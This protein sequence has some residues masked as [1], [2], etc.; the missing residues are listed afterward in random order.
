MAYTN[1][2]IN[3]GAGNFGSYQAAAAFAIYLRGKFVTPASA[4]GKA[5]IDLAGVTET[6]DVVAMTPIAS[7]AW[8]TV[9]FANSGGE[10]FGVCSGTIAIGALVYAAASGKVSADSS[11]G[12]LLL[13][14]A[15]SAGFDGGVITYATAAS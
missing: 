8:G 12:A 4:D 9:R 2:T 6:T 1:K 10:Q 15:T 3:E 11:G 7:G 13:G 5:K 14:R